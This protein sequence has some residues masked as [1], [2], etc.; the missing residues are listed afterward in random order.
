[1]SKTEDLY[2]VRDVRQVRA[3]TSPVRSRILE[4]LRAEGP[5]SAAGLAVRL[6]SSTAG[7]LYHLKLL[8]ELGLVVSAGKQR[9]GPRSEQVYAAV[10][11]Q[12][13]IVREGG[14]EYQR[15]LLD[16][17]HSTFKT[18]LREY[19]AA[20][21][22]VVDGSA[23]PIRLVRQVGLLTQDEQERVRAL[24]REAAEIVQE[25]KEGEPYSIT[26]FLLPLDGEDTV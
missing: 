25:G 20:H 16:L 22:R 4:I 17:A 1:M 6:G 23:K 5:A 11:R 26:A 3:L 15:A 19:D 7:M 10:A 13:R 12:I 24:M 18:V 21:Q 2:T 14:E 8:S 9:A